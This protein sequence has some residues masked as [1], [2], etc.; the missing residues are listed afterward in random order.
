[1]AVHDYA[2]L[3]RARDYVHLLSARLLGPRS[4]KEDRALETIHYGFTN[5]TFP[6]SIWLCYLPRCI[7]IAWNA[8]IVSGEGCCWVLHPVNCR[9]GSV[10][11]LFHRARPR[12]A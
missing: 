7:H 4:A 3:H 5:G 1:M 6:F 12:I 11:R 8:Y 10:I 9:A 2:K